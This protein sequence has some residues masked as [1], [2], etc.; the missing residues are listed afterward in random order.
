[1]KF[2]YVLVTIFS[3]LLFLSCTEEFEELGKD[4]VAI[5]ENPNGQ[6]SFA[7]LSMS[8]D[9]YYQWR[10]NLIYSGGF[11]QHYSGSWNVT[12]FGARFKKND[13]YAHS[14]WR[15]AY[16]IEM[17]NM[18]DIIEKTNDEPS[19][20]NI[21]AVAKIMKVMIAHRLT[22]LYGDIPYSEAGLGFSGGIATPVYDKQEDI[23]NSFFTE[24]EASVNQ[25]SSSGDQLTGDLFYGG[26]INKWKKLANTLRL[27]L[28]MRISEVNPAKAQEQVN[29]AVQAGVFTSN[30][31]NC[32][33]QH[34]DQS[35]NGSLAD[36]RGNGLAHAFIGNAN[37]DHFSSLLID[38]LRDHN[39]PRLPML[40]TEKTSSEFWGPIQPG[41]EVYVGITPGS[42]RW[43]TPG[44]SNA[45]SGIQDYYKKNTT[46]FLHVGYSE[47]QLLL[48]EAAQRNWISGSAADY[49]K[50]GVEAG[51]K[52]LEMYGA[53]AANQADIDNYLTA[54]PLVS[55]SELEQIGTQLWVTYLFNSV[56]AYSNQRRTGFPV[57]IPITASDSETGG[58]TPKRFYYPNDELQKNE[59]NYLDA[60]SR[61]GGVNDWLQPVW[62]DIN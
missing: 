50:K 39:D 46:P 48:A 25:L 53:P 11:T 15:R 56:E 20:V 38:F 52:Q 30:D 16:S 40:A 37:S 21:N 34:I 26:D 33:M 54:N 42:F 44:G 4:P 51:V 49:Y 7:Q 18:V 9:R 2:K 24:L 31:D 17:K 12:N 35:F 14:F 45:V 19:L 32:V 8:G 3:I 27:R 6:L 61:I 29:A 57:L 62:W 36:Y 43:E 22:D 47:S 5:S 60:L 1:M 55:G 23:Y 13:D 10:T 41:E 28:A 58:V 59:T